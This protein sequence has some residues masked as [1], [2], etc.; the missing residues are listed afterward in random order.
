MLQSS[1]TSVRIQSAVEKQEFYACYITDKYLN[2]NI[3]Y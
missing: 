2:N 3:L 1:L